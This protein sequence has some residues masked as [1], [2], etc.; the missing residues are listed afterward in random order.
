MENEYN[1]LNIVKNI[2][3]YHS[4]TEI[5]EIMALLTNFSDIKKTF[6]SYPVF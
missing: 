5:F 3:Y 4:F 2:M 6:V 1:E